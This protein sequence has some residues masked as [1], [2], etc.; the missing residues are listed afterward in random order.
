MFPFAGEAQPTKKFGESVRSGGGGS[1]SLL[2]WP[3]EKVIACVCG[4]S[5]CSLLFRDGTWPGLVDPSLRLAF[6]SVT[7]G[8]DA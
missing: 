7:I 1:V 4:T 6:R 5:L 8:G 3:M 2:A